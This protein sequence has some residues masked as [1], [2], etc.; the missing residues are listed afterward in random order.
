M[1]GVPGE[2]QPT[3]LHGLDDQATHGGDTLVED[4]PLGE[5]LTIHYESL[6]QLFPDPVV[7]SV[8]GHIVGPA[9]QYRG[10]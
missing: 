9:L 4:R 1:R 8:V 10:G 6:V 5:S 2:E 3:V 7:R